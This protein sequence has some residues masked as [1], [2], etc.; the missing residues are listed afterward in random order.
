[1]D[2]NRKDEPNRTNAKFCY[3]QKSHFLKRA[4]KTDKRRQRNLGE[5]EKKWEIP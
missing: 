3:L 2:K 4:G 1:M 5:M